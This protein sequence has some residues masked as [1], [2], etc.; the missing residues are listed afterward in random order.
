M[1]KNQ[2]L[3][4]TIENMAKNKG[5][6]SILIYVCMCV[7]ERQSSSGVQSLIKVE[8]LQQAINVSPIHITVMMHFLC[9]HKQSGIR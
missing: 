6:Y 2:L 3:T 9:S 5:V 4:K 8:W 7:I 1:N